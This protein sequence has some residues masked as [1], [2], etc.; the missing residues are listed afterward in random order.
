MV[1]RLGITRDAFIAECGESEHIG[2]RTLENWL[3]E[4]GGAAKSSP[5]QKKLDSLCHYFTGK[6][7]SEVL[8]HD[9][10]YWSL[11][12][13]EAKAATLFQRKHQEIREFCIPLPT[14]LDTL[15]PATVKY[16]AGTYKTYRYSFVGSP[17]QIVT[18]IMIVREGAV[19]AA[20]DVFIL[21]HPIS[22]APRLPTKEA[23]VQ[24]PERFLGRLCKFGEAV[25]VQAGY[26]NERS[27]DRR[28][29]SL[30]F[31]NLTNQR[32]VHYGLVV[33]YSANLEE[34]AAGR[35]I[36]VKIDREPLDEASASIH[37]QRY[38]PSDPEMAPYK[39]LLNNRIAADDAVL[40]VEKLD[41][42]LTGLVV[43]V[44]DD[45]DENAY[46]EPE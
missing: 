23:R 14:R 2:F 42:A 21:G 20:L 1:A 6:F 36:A 33:G 19:P 3:P 15:L 13:F 34:P 43:I 7:G 41:K 9:F 24:R 38:L 11:E 44:H 17:V 30:H 40:S 22:A 31:P 29:R 35:I 28:M 37:V 4:D 32:T 39:A 5:G 25:Y 26:F 16:L 27:H 12:E 10:F 45:E 18:E 8:S 46:P